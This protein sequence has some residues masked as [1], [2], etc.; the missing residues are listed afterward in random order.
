MK[1][2]KLSPHLLHFLS[3]RQRETVSLLVLLGAGLLVCSH[4]MAQTVARPAANVLPVKAPTGWVVRGDAS[5]ATYNTQ[6][7]GGTVTLKGPSSILKWNSFDVGRSATLNFKLDTSTARVLNKV[8][9]GSLTRSVI[10]GALNSNGQVYIY[11]PNGVMFGKDSKVNVNSL[12]VSTLKIDDDRFMNGLLKPSIDPTFAA[13]GLI[14]IEPGAI[15]VESGLDDATGELKQAVISAEKNGLIMLMAPQVNNDGVLSAQDG[16]VIMAAGSKVYL[17]APANSAMRG[18]RV[19]VSGS[20]LQSL[21]SATNSTNGVVSVERGNATM[22]GMLVNQNGVVSATTSV[23]LNG[24]IILKAQHGA[25]KSGTNTLAIATLGGQLVLGKGSETSVTPVLILKDSKDPTKGFE[26]AVPEPAGVAFKSSTIDLSGHAVSFEENAAVLAKSGKVTIT[27]GGPTKAGLTGVALKNDLKTSQVNFA[28][29]SVVDVSGTQGIIPLAM[30]SNVITAELRGNELADNVL[31]KSNLDIRGKTVR[32]DKRKLKDITIANL[33]GF[34]N[35]AESDIGQFTAAGGTVSVTSQGSITQAAGSRINVSG[36]W[37]DIKD[38]HINTTKLTFKGKTFAIEGASA[39]VAYDGLVNPIDGNSN[40]ELGY[41]EGKDAGTVLMNAPELTLNGQFEGSTTAG[42]YQ[43]DAGSSSRPL[44]GQIILG[45][46]S[47]DTLNATTGQVTFGALLNDEFAFA[48]DISIGG[49][50]VSHGLNLVLPE[51]TAQGFSRI[52][53]I[54]KGNISVNDLSRDASGNLVSSA[55]TMPFGG[56]LRLGAGGQ[57]TWAAD[58][59]MPGGNVAISAFNGLNVGKSDAPLNIDLSGVWQNDVLDGGKLVNAQG[60]SQKDVIINGGTFRAFANQLAVGDDVS[61]NVSGGAWLTAKGT[62]TSLNKGS[63]GTIALQ[64]VSQSV[65]ADAAL[66]LG[67]RVGFYGYGLSSG[68]SLSL[69]GRDVVIGDEVIGNGSPSA[70]VVLSADFFAQ[71]G[72]AS[73]SITANGNLKVADGAIVRSLAQSFVLADNHATRKS[74]SSLFDPLNPTQSLAQVGLW[75]LAGHSGQQR[76]ASSLTLRARG[77]A[78]TPLDGYGILSI[79]Q[80]AQLLNDPG[81]RITLSAGQQLHVD[82]TLRALGGTIS[83]QL[84]ASSSDTYNPKRSI[85]LGEHAS[86]L[87]GGSAERVYINAQGVASG[88]VLSGGTIEFGSPSSSGSSLESAVGYIVAE[89]GSVMDVS[90][91]EK[92]DLRFKSGNQITAARNIGSAGGTINVL[93]RE[94][95]VLEGT[96]SGRAGNDQVR[97]GTLNVSLDRENS[98]GTTSAQQKD[99]HL[100]LYASSTDALS[101]AGASSERLT[102]GDDLDQLAGNGW[103]STQTFDQGGF[104]VLRFK[105]QNDLTLAGAGAGG[106]GAITLSANKSI[107]LNAPNI[108]AAAAGG[109]NATVVHVNAP[110][111]A[112]GNSDNRYQENAGAGTDGLAAF[113]VKAKLIDLVGNSATQGFGKLNLN[114]EEDI[115]LAGVESLDAP[116]AV[117]AWKTGSRLNL[118][119]SQVYPTTLSQFALTLVGEDSTLSFLSNGQPANSVMSAAGVLSAEAAHIIQAG[120]V[121]APFGKISLSASKDIVYRNGSV[122]SVAGQGV[123]PFGAVVNGTDWTYSFNGSGQTM[124][125]R[126]QPSSDPLLVERALPGKSISTVAP[127]V[128]QESGALLDL[129]GGGSLYAYEFLPGPG[130]SGDVLNSTGSNNQNFA[131][132]ANFKSSAA[133]VDWHNGRDGMAV[134]DQVY[135]SGGNGIAA[136]YYTLLPAHYALLS[137]GYQI[138]AQSGTKDM[139]VQANRVNADGSTTIAGYRT[140]SLDAKSDARWSGFTVSPQSLIR[141]RSEFAE[142]D[143]SSFFTAA[144]TRL[145]QTTPVVPNDGG[146]AVFS[147]VNKLVLDGTTRMAGAVSG[148][149][150]KIGKRGVVDITAPLINVVSSADT[151]TGDYVKLVAADLNAIGADSILL[152]GI[153]SSQADGTHVQ[154]GASIVRVDNNDA[155]ALSAPEVIL[156]AKDSVQLTSRAAITANAAPDL[157]SSALIID[158]EGAGSDGALLRISGG[159]ST[160]IAR[161]PSSNANGRLEIGQGAQLLGSAVEMDATRSMAFDG[162]LGLRKGASLSISGSRLS[163]GA[164]ASDEVDGVT[165]DASVLGEYSQLGSLTLGS[166]STIDFYGNVSLGNQGRSYSIANLSLRAKALR[167]MGG[168]ATIKAD[169]INLVGDAHPSAAIE[170]GDATLQLQARRITL[171]EGTLQVQGFANTNLDASEEIRAIGKQGVLLADKHVNITSAQVSTNAAAA[172]T[173]TAA[174]NLVMKSTDTT[175]TALPSGLGG[176]LTFKGSNVTSN[177]DVQAQGG[178]VKV[179]ADHDLNL[180]GGSIDVSGRSVVFGSAVASAPAGSISLAAGDGSI[181]VDRPAT[182]N[183]SASNAAAGTLSVTSGGSSVTLD[184][185]LLGQA[186]STGGQANPL[187]QGSFFMDVAQGSSSEQFDALNDKLNAAGMTESRQF[188]VRQGDVV[189]GAQGRIQSH[190]VNISVDNGNLTVAGEIDASG[191]KGGSVFLAAAQQQASANKGRL[192]LAS[193]AKIYAQALASATS[194]AGSKGDGGKVVLSASNADGSANTSVL[195]G[196]AVVTELGTSIIVSCKGEGQAGSVTLIAPRVGAGAGS[197]VSAVFKSAVTGTQ[198]LVVEDRNVYLCSTI[199]VGAD[200]ATNLDAC[201]TGK[202]ALDAAAFARNQAAILRR[203]AR[204]DLTI[205]ITSGI[206]VRSDGDLTVSVNEQDSDASQRGWNLNT[207]RFGGQAGTL[208]LRAKGNLDIQGSIS[209]GFVKGPANTAMPNWELSTSDKSWSYRLVGGADMTSA[210]VLN[211]K[212]SQASGDVTFNF[213]RTLEAD[214]PVPVAL[215]RTGTGSIDV[216]AGRDIRLASQKLPDPDGDRSFDKTIGAAV[217]TAGHAVSLKEGFT[218]PSGTLNPDFGNATNTSAAFGAKGGSIKLS[219]QR[220]VVGPAASQLVN[221]WLFR[222]GRSGVDGNGQTVFEK[223]ATTGT[224]NTAWWAR[225]D[226]FD[227]GI[228]TFGGGDVSVKAIQGSVKDLTVNVAT[229]GYVPGESPE[230]AT[231]NEQGGG[232]LLVRAGSDIL[233]GSYYTQKG[234]ANLHADGSIK[235]GSLQALD[236]FATASGDGEVDVYTAVRPVIAMGDT[237]VSISAGKALEIET[238][239]NPTYAKQSQN[240]VKNIDRELDPKSAFLGFD[241]QTTA[242]LKYKQDFAQYSSFSTYTDQSS[243]SMVALGGDVLLSNNTQLAMGLGGQSLT[244]AGRFQPYVALLGYAPPTLEV[245]ALAGNVTSNGGFAMAP[246]SVGNLALM[247]DQSITLNNANGVY[248]SIVMLD[249]DP[250]A[251]STPLKPTLVRT[252]DLEVIQGVATGLSAH[253]PNNL[254]GS[255]NTPVTIMAKLGSITGSADAAQSLVLPKQASIEAGQDI[256]DLGFTIQH[257]RADD[258]TYV[259]AGGNFIDS[260]NV[261]QAGVVKHVISGPGQLALLAGGDIDLG[262]AAGVITRGNLDNPYLDNGGASVFAMA[263]ANFANK[264]EALANPFD[265]LVSRKDFFNALV[266]TA[267]LESLLQAEDALKT[268]LDQGDPASLISFDEALVKAFPGYFS[269]ELPSYTAEDLADSDK[270]A[271]VLKAF[272][273]VIKAGL[274]DHAPDTPLSNSISSQALARQGFDAVMT[275]FYPKY[276]DGKVAPSALRSKDPKQPYLGAFDTLAQGAIGSAK[277]GDIK[278]FGSQFKTEQGGS[279][280]LLAGGSII[281][282]LTSIPSYLASKSASSVGLFTVRGGNIRAFVKKDILVNQGRIFTLQAGEDNDIYLVSQEGNIDAGKGTKTAASAPPPLLTTDANGNTVLDISGSIAGS[283]I[284][285]GGNFSAVSPRGSFDAGDAGVKSKGKVSL[286]AKVVLNASNIAAGGGVASSVSIGTAPAASAAPTSNTSEEAAKQLT[287][288]PKDTLALTVE[289]L[290]YGEDGEEDDEEKKKRKREK[291]S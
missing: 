114:A 273:E 243:I 164:D 290:G 62:T 231:L 8:E 275:S 242:A 113:N 17:A 210:N 106:T 271:R 291:Q 150:Q 147:V 75:N 280:D 282:G 76:Q 30:E 199:S 131:I 174:G 137:G 226:Y 39:D 81:A 276:F 233:G 86:L 206:E 235:A 287:V 19:E 212:A 120:R 177:M 117:G 176:S 227:T 92:T 234:T 38:G 79:G 285:A 74:A 89:R 272:D 28:T 42:L 24:S 123:V 87:A 228:A 32:F 167:S 83:L 222:Q 4:G 236:A 3:R 253:T 284:Q 66:S 173:F 166:L 209:D 252:A 84:G 202:M 13:D 58:L 179:M 99:R 274:L 97:A 46:I 116:V 169:V 65:V 23:N 165:L 47:G 134:G 151:E 190:E 33:S 110:Y 112:M 178:Q 140:S 204:N 60:V 90:G 105:S 22:A 184:G 221:Q 63:G 10:D 186:T 191:D 70:D 50:G 201:L 25:E 267:N 239:Y 264:D 14:R 185:T 48:G 57:L 143:A 71:G 124:V 157:A 115:R 44:G 41:R 245:A 270:A 232:D 181:A 45:G 250:A 133:P 219:A 85:W 278:V 12:V 7:A 108:L 153:R 109:D 215:V 263:G 254:H 217:Y 141:K 21:A 246:S 2:V 136:G 37:L 255:D 67:E 61:V 149:G 55:L 101:L 258:R 265:S 9:G 77:N 82:G 240:N 119:A 163:L 244:H 198:S 213:A 142:Y 40:A 35:L 139:T 188:R 34:A 218:G 224:L 216:A 126:G 64:A 288:A 203:L 91:V 127:N 31:L 183:L 230:G 286:I 159:A 130:G 281:A 247:A 259:S 248:S 5:N 260:T 146:Q 148:T 262:N 72:F 107:E 111:V 220:D 128:T 162:Q 98:S 207:W 152:G 43:R 241:L 6:G 104:G 194:E 257:N 158:G 121:V 78:S 138:T 171:G 279:L 80:G 223:V 103:L 160:T 93:A 237:Q 156:V 26:S 269:S 20:G 11:N 145:K 182:L 249:A 27:A 68:G 94:G 161:Q 54:T 266:L 195:G 95:L 96:M 208:T 69:T 175:A 59:K 168:D 238:I 170:N 197:D 122:T 189:L 88:D 200:S 205:D 15:T 29:G 1:P 129:S 125:L 102:A 193:T 154:V 268:P 261:Q 118:T 187:Q 251:L 18:L 73:R 53:A 16:Q 36:G 132:N 283:G 180:Q 211:V 51:L 229:N 172:A 56:Q 225:T 192:T 214:K 100:T 49:G 289:V 155:H 277:A 196:A 52:T 256:K 135:L 144:A